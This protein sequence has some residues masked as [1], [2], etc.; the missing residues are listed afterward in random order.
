[1]FCSIVIPVYN[2]IKYLPECLDS[3]VKQD[4]PKAEYEVICVDDCSTDGSSE[5]LDRYAASYGDVLKIY[6]LEKNGGVSRA[7]NYGIE[8]SS[9]KY[10]YFLDADDFID[11]GALS[12]VY[13]SASTDP[14]V[15]IAGNYSLKKDEFTPEELALKK[16]NALPYSIWITGSYFYKK[17]VLDEYYVRYIEGISLAEDALFRYDFQLV[18]KTEVQSDKII[19]YY[20]NVPTG[21]MRKPRIVKFDSYIGLINRYDGYLER[22]A[23]DPA[24][25]EY[26]LFLR[27]H[28]CL[29]AIYELP[30]YKRGKYIRKLKTTGYFN[31]KPSEDAV[32]KFAG[33]KA[34]GKPDT[35]DKTERSFRLAST[36]A[37]RMLINL[38]LKKKK[39]KSLFG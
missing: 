24:F 34:E 17:E 14:D 23:G 33:K 16:E 29:T 5:V 6:H 39:I 2:K 7:R 18:Q 13:A 36:P 3:C 21:L 20:R 9:G 10:V 27:V 11:E 12:T 4:F 32:L 28:D 30:V 38:R 1:M 22:N 25:L 8:K 15:I 31:K 37:G 35:S 26:N 19:H